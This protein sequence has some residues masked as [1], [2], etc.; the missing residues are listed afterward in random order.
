MTKRILRCDTAKQYDL[1]RREIGGAIRRVLKSGVYILGK[2]VELFETEFARYIGRSYGVAVASGTDAITLAL[3][4]AGL[5]HGDEVITST[6]APTPVPTAIL[7]AGGVPVFAD[8]RETTCLVDPARIEEKVSRKTRFILPVHVFG[9]VCDM[10]S[11]GEIAKRRRVTVIE[12]AAQAHGSFLRGRAA[13]SFGSLSCFSFYPTKNLGGYGDGGMVLT[14]FGKIA[15]RLRLL[16]NYGKE[17]NPFDSEILGY[18][19]RLDEVQAAVLRVKLKRLDDM[20]AA[21]ERIARLYAEALRGLPVRFFKSGADMRPN[22]HVMTIVCGA[23]RGGLAR[24]LQA[25]NIQTNVYYPR[26]LH[27]MKP[28]RK[29]AGPKD[30]FPVSEKLSKE[31]L[32]IPLYPELK[33]ADA[34]SVI[35][36]IRDYFGC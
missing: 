28:F 19:S 11:I 23:R 8:I 16:R 13:G 24:F 21:R 1:Y 35:D 32:A 9:Y 20:N 26:P 29:Y 31:I 33:K 22:Y 7:L 5:K 27:M 3:K 18:N 6:Y 34:L 2:E 36:A 30:R 17:K 25:K 14:D 15:G 12:D 4:A 10:D